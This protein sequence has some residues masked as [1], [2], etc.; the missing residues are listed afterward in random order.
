MPCILYLSKKPE[1]MANPFITL[2]YLKNG[3][4]FDF[5]FNDVAIS[6][7]NKEPLLVSN[8]SRIVKTPIEFLNGLNNNA[9]ALID[10]NTSGKNLTLY[11]IQIEGKF[12]ENQILKTSDLS[13]YLPKS[14]NKKQCPY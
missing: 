2:C 1:F 11:F 4:S 7:R 5:F 9:Y 13:K 6:I 3:N 14:F 12:D 10:S 8:Y